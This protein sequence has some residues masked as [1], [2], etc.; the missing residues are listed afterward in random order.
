[1]KYKDRLHVS[2]EI[3]ASKAGTSIYIDDYRI[4]GPK[5]PGGGRVINKFSASLS[6]MEFALMNKCSPESPE[7]IIAN[8]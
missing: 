5:P 2:I 1:M 8:D 6:D 4:A 3:I 7:P